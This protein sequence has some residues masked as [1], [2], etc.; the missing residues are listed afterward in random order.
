MPPQQELSLL[1][2]QSSSQDQGRVADHGLTGAKWFRSSVRGHTGVVETDEVATV[3]P[4]ETH[5][6]RVLRDRGLRVTRPRM[7]VLRVVSE[8]PHVDAGFVAR[9]LSP[10]GMSRQTVYGNL[11]ALVSAR[12]LRRIEPANSPA[13]Y[14]LRV[15]GDDHH[16]LM[17]RQCRQVF[18]TSLTTDVRRST[19]DP[20]D[21]AVDGVDVFFWGVC[22]RCRGSHGYGEGNRPV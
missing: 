2:H 13:L 6:K 8:H 22:G 16:H 17:C 21:F 4:S 18:D 11:D 14:E 9:T 10:Q 7:R 15:D 20:D 12:L 3:A 19:G 5:W 1:R